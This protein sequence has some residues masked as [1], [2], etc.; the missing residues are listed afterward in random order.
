MEVRI[1]KRHY[2]WQPGQV[3]ELTE[4][5]AAK[6]LRDGIAE[7][8]SSQKKASPTETDDSELPAPLTAQ[9]EPVKEPKKRKKD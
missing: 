5:N 3:V 1:V 4:G 6:L 2:N 7:E 8:V 9:T